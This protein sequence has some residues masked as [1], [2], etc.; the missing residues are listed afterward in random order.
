[1]DSALRSE[2]ISYYSDPIQK[3]DLN[4]Y[5]RNGNQWKNNQ[6]LLVQREEYDKL[7][8]IFPSLLGY[9]GIFGKTCIILTN[10][11]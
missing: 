9:E 10:V 6:P 7:V 11:L 3:I 4:E 1:M 2:K 8:T 5:H